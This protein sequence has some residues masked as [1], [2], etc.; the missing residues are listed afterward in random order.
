MVGVT[1]PKSLVFHTA[2][3]PQFVDREAGRV[4]AQIL[5]LGLAGALLQLL[6]DGVW[7]LTVSTTRD[8]LGRSPRGTAL[9]GGTGGLAMIGLGAGMAV[10]GRL[11]QGRPY[12]A[13]GT[14]CGA[15]PAESA[16]RHG[17]KS[18]GRSRTRGRLPRR[19][20]TGRRAQ[21]HP[22]GARHDVCVHT[23]AQF[24]PARARP[25]AALARRPRA[26][27]HRAARCRHRRRS[28]DR[29]GIAQHAV[30]DGQGRLGRRGRLRR[31]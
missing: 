19:P 23:H 5:F 30:P 31:G 16:R 15:R 25:C 6:F 2:V 20:R 22:R 10:T 14:S 1:N 17:I 9:I 13:A 24:S 3:L 11:D 7:G 21:H 8:W 27:R 29:R 28:A 4:A 18:R 26:G 12:G